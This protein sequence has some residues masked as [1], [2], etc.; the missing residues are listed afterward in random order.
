MS[1]S[2]APLFFHQKGTSLC[3]LHAV[4]NIF[5]N[6]H[7]L[8][9]DLYFT[10][11]DM[12]EAID[13]VIEAF[14]KKLQP[15]ST[16]EAAPIIPLNF[17]GIKETETLTRQ[18]RFAAYVKHFVGVKST[19]PVSVRVLNTMLGK[20]G[21]AMR[22]IPYPFAKMQEEDYKVV[23]NTVGGKSHPTIVEDRLYE[24]FNCYK[25]KKIRCSMGPED[26]V[27]LQRARMN[28]ILF[29]WKYSKTVDETPSIK[30]GP[31]HFIC[32]NCN[33]VVFDNVKT[34]KGEIK[35]GD[36]TLDCITDMGVGGCK[37][38][39]E[40]DFY[41]Y[42]VVSQSAIQDRKTQFHTQF[43]EGLLDQ[44]SVPGCSDKKKNLLMSIE[45]QNRYWMAEGKFTRNSYNLKNELLEQNISKSKKARIEAA[46]SL[47]YPYFDPC[48][49]SE[50][51]EDNE[52]E[53]NKEDEVADDVN[54]V[55]F[56][57]RRA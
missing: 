9:K 47:H 21:Y 12:N 8:K 17:P 37:S 11:D 28:L 33:G 14:K 56:H 31:A 16:D 18:Q 19:G 42:E 45:A 6:N 2:N 29:C 23:E 34:N 24:F 4:N 49:S 5:R 25:R 22:H 26:L 13:I 35:T 46:N 54:D 51:E 48:V 15:E 39:E 52:K 44:S 40:L 3:G 53:Y 1:D 50:D 10:I 57:K 27:I 41:A 20:K 32:V 36:F 7:I 30:V 43:A 55:L 38:G